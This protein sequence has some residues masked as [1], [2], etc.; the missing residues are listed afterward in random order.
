VTVKRLIEEEIHLAFYDP[1]D[2]FNK[3]GA[4]LPVHL[5]P[6]RL[7]RAISRINVNVTREGE[8]IYSYVFADKGKSLERLEKHKGFFE[9]DNKQRQGKIIFIR[10]EDAGDF[11]EVVPEADAKEIKKIEHK[12]TQILD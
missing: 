7:R 11:L 9:V 1:I 6:E 3:D 12:P 8:R 2:M 4:E 10:H 5:M